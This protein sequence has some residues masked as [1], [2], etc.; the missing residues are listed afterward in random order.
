MTSL[1]MTV[2]ERIPM[3][4]GPIIR[5]ELAGTS[6]TVQ[7]VIRILKQR[8]FLILFIW[9]LIF[10]LTVVG[11][12][13]WVRYWP[14]YT[15]MGQVVVE[16]P[17]PKA[18]MEFTN[19]IVQVDLLDRA[20]ADQMVRL[21]S[22]GL[23]RD[24]ITNDARVRETQWFKSGRDANERVQALQGS[25]SVK[26]IPQTNY[27]LVSLSTRN[28]E[29][30]P[31]IINQLIDKYIFETTTGSQRS[32]REELDTYTREEETIRARLQ[33]LRNQQA[34][35]LKMELTEPG[36]IK[37][38]NIVGETW[39]VLAQEAARIGT[40]KLQYQAQYENLVN[41]DP[42]QGVITPQMRMMIEQDPEVVQLQNAR[43]MQEQLLLAR[44]QQGL[45]ENH[46]EI[47]ELRSQLQSIDNQ[48][49]DARARKE[50][51]V[52]EAEI[53]Q[54]QTLYFNA[55]HAEQQLLEQ[56]EQ[57][58]S[59]QRDLDR[60]IVEYE[61]R[62]KEYELL[63]QHLERVS[64][65]I[66][67]LNMLIRT[68]SAIRLSG[69]R[70]LV[71]LERSSPRWEYNLPAGFMLGLLLGVGLAVLLEF[72]DTS[73]KTGR[74]VIR[75][76]HVPVLGTVPDLDDEEIP[77]DAI[78][79]A[80]HVAPRSMVAEAFRNIRTNLLLTCPADR[81]RTVLITSPRPEDGRTAVAVNLAISLAQSGRRVLLVDANFHRPRLRAIFPKSNTDGLSNVLLGRVRLADVVSKTEL[82]NLDVLTTGPIPPN[83]TELLAATYLQQ[84]ITQ[85][86]ERYDQVIFDGPPVLLVSDVLVMTPSVD[87]VILV[88]RAQNTSRGV[89]QRAREQIERVEG[90]VFGA[91]LNAAQVTRGG[92]FREQIRSYYD[93]QSEQLLAAEA[94]RELPGNQ[95][96]EA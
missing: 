23:L 87:G 85:A 83:P 70:A 55:M 35:F 26:Q 15:A 90:H 14:G 62:E 67:Q 16:S 22:E 32:Y 43:V 44:Q 20:V 66:A 63:Q 13:L 60:Q 39:R 19:P 69:V 40:E 73:L 93:Y 72:I 30:A 42:S 6:I 41:R 28:P 61:N 36:A 11:T 56:I 10:G 38:I 3:P 50:Q 59:K 81:Q 88:F 5:P 58:R 91:I 29:D 79:L 51:A 12:Y 2:Q 64:D 96:K 7:D 52:L 80:P 65:Y 25:L 54:A 27:I 53:A 86:T 46:R 33:N 71:P 18:P 21:K 24:L 94:R 31:V 1:P 89:A 75:H 57:E 8:I 95:G 48:L 4:M 84:V 45:G 9:I 92:Y 34:D 37:G 82:P 74:D 68:T 78:E 76:V 17:L 49:A 47:R 77:I